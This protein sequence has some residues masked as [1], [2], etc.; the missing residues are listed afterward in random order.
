MKKQLGVCFDVSTD[1]FPLFF[2]GSFFFYS[3]LLHCFLL[4]IFFHFLLSQKLLFFK[5]RR[6]KGRMCARRAR[7]GKKMRENRGCQQ[8][9]E[10]EEN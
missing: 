9:E 2:L 7:A 4:F 10:R 3:F 8:V 5:S 6:L 1:I